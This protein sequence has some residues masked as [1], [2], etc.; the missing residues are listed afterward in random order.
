M[1]KN[2]DP[3]TSGR[4]AGKQMKMSEFPTHNLDSF[5]I[6]EECIF[7]FLESLNPETTHPTPFSTLGSYFEMT[8]LYVQRLQKALLNKFDPVGEENK[9]ISKAL[10]GFFQKN[11]G[12]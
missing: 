2:S 9:I 7:S 5:P 11:N 10:L 4:K 12:H 6:N 3:K 1:L 8:F